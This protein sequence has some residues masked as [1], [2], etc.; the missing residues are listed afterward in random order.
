M[1]DV[2]LFCGVKGCSSTMAILVI[3]QEIYFMCL[4]QKIF[5]FHYVINDSVR[6]NIHHDAL[7]W[8][9]LVH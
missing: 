6:Y 5:W 2:L 1:S 9:I 4:C 8:L 3:L 7:P